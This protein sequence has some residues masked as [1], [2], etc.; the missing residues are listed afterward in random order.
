MRWVM[1]RVL[2][3]PAPARISSGPSTC[4]TA[5]RCSG[6]RWARR[7]WGVEDTLYF[8]KRDVLALLH[9]AGRGPGGVD[10][11]LAAAQLARWP[12]HAFPGRALRQ[13]A[14][15]GAGGHLAAC[16]V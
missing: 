16:R 12:L 2:P 4:S 5:A 6:L 1:T 11:A 10:A 8:N 9:P 15:A 3:L 13:S 14:G 7:G